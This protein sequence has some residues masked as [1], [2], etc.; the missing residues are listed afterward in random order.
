MKEAR[1]PSI[2]KVL[3]RAELV[4]IKEYAKWFLIDFFFPDIDHSKGKE[5]VEYV[6]TSAHIHA[7]AAFDDSPVPILSIHQLLAWVWVWVGGGGSG[8]KDLSSAL[9]YAPH[10]S[11]SN[12]PSI[13]LNVDSVIQSQ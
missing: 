11:Q 13:G 2:G 3:Q 6:G 7:C 8:P 9:I 5:Q 4:M 12:Q 1:A 10:L